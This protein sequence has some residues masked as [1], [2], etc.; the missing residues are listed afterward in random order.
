LAALITGGRFEKFTIAANTS[1]LATTAGGWRWFIIPAGYVGAAF[2][3]A[4]LLVL[5]HRNSRTRGRRWLAIGLGLFFL[6]MTVLFARNLTGIA[7]GVISALAL[8]ILGW[9]APP[10]L[11]LFGL[12]LLAIQSIL[13]AVDSLLGLIR[14]NAGPFQLPNDAQAMA[15]LT[16]IPAFFWA[17][18]WSVLALS[19]LIGSIYLVVQRGDGA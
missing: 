19:V 16:H 15:D 8:L 1:G 3:G 7:I 9:Y 12:N 10:L 5:I 6:L 11:L 14:L 4:L 2:F 13:N 17:V 18:L